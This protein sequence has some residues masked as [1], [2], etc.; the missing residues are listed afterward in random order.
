MHFSR[1]LIWR[2]MVAIRC[3]QLMTLAR[4]SH[5]KGGAA[6]KRPGNKPSHAVLAYLGIYTRVS[7]C[8]SR[9]TITLNESRYRALNKAAAQRNK[10]IC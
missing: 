10:T 2:K 5:D 6:M 7:N 3:D 9:L 8:M 1:G 4:Q